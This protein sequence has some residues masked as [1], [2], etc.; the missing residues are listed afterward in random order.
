M[1]VMYFIPSIST[2][3]GMERVLAEK[4]N[5][6]AG[7]DG[8]KVFIV[9]TEMNNNEK[10]FF[11]FDS[12]INIINFQLNFN[13]NF[14]NDFLKKIIKTKK[15]L[16][17]Y[18]DKLKQIVA[19]NNIDICITMGGKELEF[20][21]NLN[22]N[23]K[24]IYESHFN[25]NFRSSFLK[26]H[27]KNNLFW[28]LFGKFRDWQHAVQASKLDKIVVLTDENLKKWSNT[29]NR[30]VKIVNPSP[31]KNITD[32]RPELGSKRVIAIGK[33]D[34]QKGFDMLIE[35]WS[36]VY[37]KHPDWR[38]DIFGVGDLKNL[39]NDLINKHNL[40]DVVKLAGVTIDVKRELLNSSFLVLSSRFE[41]LPMVLIEGI[42]CGLPLVAFDCE[43]G[44]R[45]IITSNDCG[46][47]IENGNIYALANGI[48]QLIEN[49]DLLTIMS[50][51]GIN[52]SS[53]YQLDKVMKKWIL[54]FEELL[55][56]NDNRSQ[57]K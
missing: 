5:Y 40:S 53:T 16:K 48:N 30:V 36:I 49:P 44:P 17:I 50:E 9:T 34:T 28:S 54:L 11:K 26:A 8:Y 47:L 33:L 55:Y 21:G 7:V 52:K 2:S 42:S 12:S 18:E 43:T 38:L 22:L 1:N 20:I 57:M 37:Q 29:D 6:L 3:G 14:K 13:E 19:S 27:N 15:L 24:T 10:P 25:K 39:L 31:L 32:C 41:G 51:N 46:L 56:T 35:T 23:C 45:E 4:V